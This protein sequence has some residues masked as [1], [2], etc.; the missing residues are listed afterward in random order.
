MK[1]HAEPVDLFARML[2]RCVRT[3]SGCWIF[4][5]ATNSRGYSIVSNG[6]KGGNILGHQLAVMAS[7]RTVPAG[8]N[9]DHACH[10]HATCRV[11]KDCQ[12]RRCVNPAHL[13]VVT[14][15]RNTTRRWDSGLCVKGHPLTARKSDGKRQCQTC[16]RAYALRRAFRLPDAA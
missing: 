12:H 4:P 3:D 16:R 15:R 1:V 7:G 11:E 2:R 9:I 6:V 14:I 13:A 5:G 10:D 8:H